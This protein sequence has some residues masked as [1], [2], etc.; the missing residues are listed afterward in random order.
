MVNK[1][2]LEASEQGSIPNSISIFSELYLIWEAEVNLKGGI[3]NVLMMKDREGNIN[4]LP[5]VLF[6]IWPLTSIYIL[7]QVIKATYR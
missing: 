1:D 5:L 3:I 2:F 7:Y 6:I 4:Y